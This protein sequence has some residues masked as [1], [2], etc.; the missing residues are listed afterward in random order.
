MNAFNFDRDK[1]VQFLPPNLM[2][3]TYVCENL[4]EIDRRECIN[5]FFGTPQDLAISH[6]SFRGAYT[7]VV[8]FGSAP[9][10]VVGTYE[11][12][13]GVWSM[14]AFG[15]DLWPKVVVPITKFIRRELDPFI[16]SQGAHRA[17]AIAHA[18]H[19]EAH[20]WIEMLGMEREGV[21]KGYGRDGSDYVSFAWRK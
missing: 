3:I 19:T 12:W 18:D 16:K 6:F 1:Q 4:R 7:R 20:A 9:A 2:A 17:Q 8:W 13:P 14:W 5:A 15:T 11:M 21:L 10:A